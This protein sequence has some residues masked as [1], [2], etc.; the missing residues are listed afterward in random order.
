MHE[1]YLTCP[2]LNPL[3]SDII[4]ICDSVLA[5]LRVAVFFSPHIHTLLT[6]RLHK[7][8]FV[9]S[10]VSNEQ[11]VTVWSNVLRTSLFTY[12]IPNYASSKLPEN[13][14][15]Y[16]QLFILK[17]LPTDNFPRSL[18]NY[19]VLFSTKEYTRKKN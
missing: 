5:Q 15:F 16:L 10:N 11:F 7:L 3:E 9:D 8:D 1:S 18:E 12:C 4:P 19:K 13:G 17:P 6:A 2:A 14:D